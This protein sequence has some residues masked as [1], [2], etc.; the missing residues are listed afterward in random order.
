M[1]LLTATCLN[2]LGYVLKSQAKNDESKLMYEEALDIRTSILGT[3]HPET[4]VS[5]HNLA[6]L[7]IVT[8]DNEKASKLQ[9]QILEIVGKSNDSKD[10]IA[11]S[12]NNSS[13]SSDQIPK[14]TINNITSVTKTQQSTKNDKDKNNN[15]DTSLDTNTVKP[16]TRKKKI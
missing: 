9:H 15:E 4:I 1:D 3:K 13:N 6:E 12:G 7:L 5:M 16:S 11:I 8:G 2:N 10:D 14:K